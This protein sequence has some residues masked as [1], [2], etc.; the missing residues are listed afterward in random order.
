MLFRSVDY[1]RDG[2]YDTVVEKTVSI[3]HVTIKSGTKVLQSGLIGGY[4]SGKNTVY[5]TNCKVEKDV[6]IGYDKSKSNIG[7]FAGDLNGIITNSTSEATVYGVDQVGG[8]AGRKGQS[9]G[10]C[11]IQNSSFS[12]TVEGSGKWIGGIIGQGYDGLGSAP[13]TMCVV[14]NNCFVKGSVIGDNYVGGIF[15]G[16]PDCKQNWGKASIT[17]NYF[18]GTVTV[19]EAEDKIGGIIGYMTSLNKNNLIQNNY[20][21]SESTEKGIG[22]AKYID[23]STK[24]HGWTSNSETYYMNTTTDNL[25]EIEQEINPDR[26]SVV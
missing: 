26:K 5:I 15:G 16:E 10:Y 24:T 25:K 2:N 21:V 14:I 12:G 11:N 9:M 13:N 23:T 18:V 8:L 19:S 7:S 6:V 3:D 1:G 4:A 22:G 20:Y 17:D